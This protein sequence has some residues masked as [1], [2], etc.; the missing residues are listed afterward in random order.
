[1]ML[2]T[3]AR[4]AR[5]SPAKRSAAIAATA[6]PQ[7]ELD[8]YCLTDQQKQLVEDNV[9]LLFHTALKYYNAS[10]F[11]QSRFDSSDDAVSAGA[12]GMM[13]AAKL[14]RPELGYKFSTYATKAI[15]SH[16][17]KAAQAELVVRIPAGFFA[18]ANAERAERY[19]RHAAA[20]L[21]C[22]SISD[23][24][25]AAVTHDVLPEDYDRLHQRVDELDERERSIIRMYFWGGMTMEAIGQQIGLTRERVRQIRDAALQ[26]LRN[27]LN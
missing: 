24:M 20:A 16:I 22:H 8:P 17:L 2:A 5:T 25:E 6:A 18:K 14:F 12:S 9:G 3:P 15:R 23:D 10:P 21:N 19:A 26:G 13:R 4:T 27:T 7:E 11:L 1:M